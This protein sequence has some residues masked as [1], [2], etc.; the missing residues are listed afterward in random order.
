M[1]RSCLRYFIFLNALFVVLPVIRAELPAMR[2]PDDNLN[3]F[4]W[5]APIKTLETAEMLYHDDKSNYNT[6]IT[7]TKTHE[8]KRS[9]GQHGTWQI[10]DGKLILDSL[11][12]GEAFTIIFDSS[13]LGDN[14]LR[15]RIP[16]GKW[17]GHVIVLQYPPVAGGK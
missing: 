15:G 16:K 2:S 7:F 17:S 6:K 3:A 10:K 14:K 13:T 4:L 12:T 11:D 8:F 9:D 5:G 1:I